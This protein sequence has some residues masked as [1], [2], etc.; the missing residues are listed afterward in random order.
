MQVQYRSSTLIFEATQEMCKITLLCSPENTFKFGFKE[1]LYD[2]TVG[3]TRTF[4][5]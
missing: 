1:N 2:L 5:I 3:N 4:H